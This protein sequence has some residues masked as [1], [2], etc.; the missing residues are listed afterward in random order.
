[1][2]TG[3]NLKRPLKIYS[4]ELLKQQKKLIPQGTKPAKTFKRSFSASLKAV[5]IVAQENADNKTYNFMK[6]YKSKA[7]VAP[8]IA[9]QR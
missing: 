4:I 8:G 9:E 3:S 1:M 7:F 2:S 6:S 5:R